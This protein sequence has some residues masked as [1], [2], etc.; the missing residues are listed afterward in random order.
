[1]QNSTT[2]HLLIERRLD[3]QEQHSHRARIEQRSHRARLLAIEVTRLAA[4][5]VLGIG[6]TNLRPQW[7]DV[8]Q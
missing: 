2:R 4:L 1:M 3:Q 7:T 8:S 5:A 6:L